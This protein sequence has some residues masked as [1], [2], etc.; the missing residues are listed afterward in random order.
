M[1]LH[2]NNSENVE[3]YCFLHY[4]NDEPK[5]RAFCGGTHPCMNM[6][7]LTITHGL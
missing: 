1:T 2:E 6:L 3:S 5:A 7:D 4:F